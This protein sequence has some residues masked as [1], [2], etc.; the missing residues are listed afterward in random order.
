MY[1]AESSRCSDRGMEVRLLALLGGNYDRSTQRLTD[2]RTHKEV[3]HPIQPKR[4][5]YSQV[6]LLTAVHQFVY[7][8]TD[9]EI[10]TEVITADWK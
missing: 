6:P 3:S 8:R 9:K 4:G 7:G 1:V 10:S 2:R 5:K